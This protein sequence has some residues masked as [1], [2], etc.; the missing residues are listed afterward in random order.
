MLVVA[1]CHS[2]G[3]NAPAALEPVAPA[4]TA[5][6]Q[7]PVASFAPAGSADTLA[8]IRV[9][10]RDDVIPLERLE[11]PDE[12]AVLAKFSI[13][14]AL[15]GHFRFLTPRM[16]GF[17]ADA[18]LPLATRV[19]VTI[20]KGLSDLHGRTL[21]QDFS[22]TFHTAGVA[23]TD[24]PLQ[25]DAQTAPGA[26]PLL[27]TIRL[28]SNTALD[29]NSLIAHGSLVPSTGAAAVGLALPP[30]S[31]TP[32][33][34][35]SPPADRGVRSV[36]ENVVVHGDSVPAETLAKGDDISH[37]VLASGIATEA[38]ATSQPAAR[39]AP[40]KI[41]TFGRAC[42]RADLTQPSRTTG[43]RLDTGVPL[44]RVQ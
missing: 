30:N 31:A 13:A 20:A 34:S 37:V 36:G 4:P 12:A 25:D 44:P 43:D 28:S 10:F 32:S 35:P 1:G 42:V 6:P 26:G 19:R 18:A 15:P 17:Q 22:W 11:S 39:R 2:G 7:G 24:L 14:P 41:R 5:S 33:S 9:I 40:G 29:V 3:S 38:R 16:I 27:P 21:A 8:Q 23:I